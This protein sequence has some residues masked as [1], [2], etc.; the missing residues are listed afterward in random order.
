MRCVTGDH[1]VPER[2]AEKTYPG[3]GPPE[4][5]TDPIAKVRAVLWYA[6]DSSIAVTNSER[7]PKSAETP[8]SCSHPFVGSS[9]GLG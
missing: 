4:L 3:Q 7:K 8:Q 6:A 9:R 2:D 5:I 1:L